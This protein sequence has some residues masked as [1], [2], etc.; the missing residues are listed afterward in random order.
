MKLYSRDVSA[1]D[2]EVP[3]YCYCIVFVVVG[4]LLKLRRYECTAPGRLHHVYRTCYVHRSYGLLAFHDSSCI[5][6]HLHH[7]LTRDKNT[8]HS[9]YT[10]H[11]YIDMSVP[12]AQFSFI[13]CLLKEMLFYY[14]H[15]Q[16]DCILCVL[17]IAMLSYPYESF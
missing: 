3:G 16:R 14:K 7:P 1:E 11:L 8:E 10:N 15:T 6:Q 5:H 17:Y 4:L 9:T 12:C 13:C 2:M